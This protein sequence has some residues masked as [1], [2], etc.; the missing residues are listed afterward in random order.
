VTPTLVVQSYRA[1]DVPVWIARCL[2]SVQTWARQAGH[3][4]RLVGDEAFVLCG[5]DYLARVGDNKRSITNL[6]RL[7]LVRDAHREGYEWAAWIDADVFVFD[8]SFSL[9][10]LER[11]AFAREVWLDMPRQSRLRA[12]G[13]T[14]NSVFVC[15]AGEPDLDF[16]IHATRHVAMHRHHRDNYQVGGDLIQGL[17]K[18]LGY[19]I[20]Y[21]AGMFSPHV[22]RALAR[23]VGDLLAIQARAYGAPVQA[24]NLCGSELYP[25]AVGETE[26]LA[27]MDRLEATKG[28]AVNQWLT[29]APGLEAGATVWFDA[30]DLE[31]KLGL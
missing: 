22:V 11:Y 7:E 25:A 15:R 14:N 12:V 17:R 23:D 6:C 21:G 5:E 28:A 18:A 9:A 1:R 13:G 30:P 3:D 26:V 27:A 31:S 8:P 29:G 20:L 10:G 19:E 16:L 2:A 4:Y 24:A